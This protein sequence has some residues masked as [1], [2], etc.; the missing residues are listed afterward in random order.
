MHKNCW[1]GRGIGRVPWRHDKSRNT[2]GM[3]ME[4]RERRGS[5]E[6]NEKPWL[7]EMPEVRGAGGW[8]AVRGQEG[9]D[10]QTQVCA[11]HS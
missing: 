8:S 10:C 2:V 7:T 5:S 1:Q 6:K 11:L 4:A 9:V 3:S